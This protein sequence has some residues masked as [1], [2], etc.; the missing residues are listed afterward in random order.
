MLERR[1]RFRAAADDT[2][3]RRSVGRTPGPLK[4]RPAWEPCGR[5]R[6]NPVATAGS[7]CHACRICMPHHTTPQTGARR[8]ERSAVARSSSACCATCAFSRAQHSRSRCPHPPARAPHAAQSMAG[9]SQSLE[10]WRWR[11]RWSPQATR[12]SWDCWSSSAPARCSHCRACT[13]QTWG[14]PEYDITDREKHRSGRWVRTNPAMG[15]PEPQRGVPRCTRL[16]PPHTTPLPQ[17]AN[18]R[19]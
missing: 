16:A 3:L 13:S 6:G 1:L 9:A 10:L 7:V 8:P 15:R 18:G 19:R 5:T 14:G 11:G 2:P 4:A 17:K 12:R